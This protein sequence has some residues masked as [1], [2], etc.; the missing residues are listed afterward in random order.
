MSPI[1]QMVYLTEP[2]DKALLEA[3]WKKEGFHFF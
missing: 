2:F 1:Q 3:V